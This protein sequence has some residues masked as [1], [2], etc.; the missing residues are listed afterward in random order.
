MNRH[1]LTWLLGAFVAFATFG[2]APR[3]FAHHILGIPHYAYDER[4]PQTPVL[5]YRMEAGPREVKMT[6]YPGVPVPGERWSLHVYVRDRDTGTPFD[7]G[8]TATVMRDRWLREDPIVYGPRTAALE[9]AVYKF[10]PEFDAEGDYLVR[11]TFEADGTPWTVDLP[12]VAG[13]PGS[14]GAVL[15][16]VMAAMLIFL[17]V[18]RAVRIKVRRHAARAP[19]RRAGARSRHPAP[20]PGLHP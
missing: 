9:E 18:I 10:Y 2:A 3:A 17:I 14:P 5:T 6:G 11:F 20:S 12:V 13:E 19:E 7:G 4:Y 8:V 16:A 1:G 15:V